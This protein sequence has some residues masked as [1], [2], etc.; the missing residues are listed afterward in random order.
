MISP[1]SCAGLAFGVGWGPV[2]DAV[3][4][5]ATGPRTGRLPAD[6]CAAHACNA[7]SYSATGVPGSSE[8]RTDRTRFEQLRGE[9]VPQG[10]RVEAAF[11]AASGA[12]PRAHPLHGRDPQM[13]GRVAAREQPHRVAMRLPE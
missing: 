11:Q 10:V 9:R 6:G 8:S 7:P 12:C 1:T 2:P 13:T 3:V 5:G 4:P